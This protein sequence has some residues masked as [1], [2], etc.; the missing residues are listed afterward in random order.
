MTT[1]SLF[2]LGHISAT[3]NALAYLAQHNL[4][5]IPFLRRHQQ[6]D[7]GCVPTEDANANNEALHNEGR[8][9]SSYAVGDGKVWLITEA[10]RS[11]TTL[12]LPDDY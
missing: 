2:P 1:N 7:W 10:D 8:L 9:L 4:T 11:A 5:P 12:L 3:P 6:G